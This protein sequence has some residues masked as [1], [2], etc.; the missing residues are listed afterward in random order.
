MGRSSLAALALLCACGKTD[1]APSTVWY[2]LGAGESL[3]KKTHKPAVIFVHAEWSSAD[4]ELEHKTFPAPEVRAAMKDFIA[5]SVDAT[6]DEDPATQAA[7]RR[8]DVKG[9][10]TIII[11]DDTKREITRF[12]EFVTAPR[13]AA[14]IRAARTIHDSRRP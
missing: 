14:S 9:V 7:L 5:I 3:M 6:D 1:V 12:N 4:K 2:D 13:L 10:P 11:L 8:F